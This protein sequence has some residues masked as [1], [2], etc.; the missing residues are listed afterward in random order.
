MTSINADRNLVKKTSDF[1]SF[2]DRLRENLRLFRRH[3]K[4]GQLPVTI[5]VTVRLSPKPG[6]VSILNRSA[7]ILAR[8]T[9]RY[10]VL[11]PNLV[12]RFQSQLKKRAPIRQWSPS[13]GTACSCWHNLRP[14]TRRRRPTELTILLVIAHLSQT[15]RLQKVLRLRI[16]SAIAISA[17][18]RHRHD[19]KNADDDDDDHQLQQCEASKTLP[20][21][22]I[23]PNDLSRLTK[24]CRNRSKVCRSPIS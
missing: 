16:S 7:S 24:P 5:E 14:F 2:V 20:R 21:Q 10:F 3:F 6:S 12:G 18:T 11:K 13:S 19:R 22:I 17:I 4:S 15:D 9:S 8:A 23:S 1:L